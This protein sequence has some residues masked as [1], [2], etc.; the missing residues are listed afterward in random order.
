MKFDEEKFIEVY[1]KKAG[2]ISATC[3]ALLVS[4]TQFYRKMKKSKKFKEAIDDAYESIIDNVE[5]KLLSKINDGDTTATIFFLKTKGKKRGYVEK[6]E[7]DST[8]EV[9]E[10][11][12]LLLPDNGRSK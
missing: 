5:S 12:Q 10:P 4:R 9:L 8:V 6:V 1:Q 11:V 7:L 2:N 3:N